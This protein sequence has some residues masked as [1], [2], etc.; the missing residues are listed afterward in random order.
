MR[1]PLEYTHS[2]YLHTPYLLTC[3]MFTFIY[4]VYIGTY[5]HCASHTS[6]T[7]ALCGTKRQ[8]WLCHS[9]NVELAQV[10]HLWVLVCGSN[11]RRQHIKSNRKELYAHYTDKRP[12]QVSVECYLMMIQVKHIYIYGSICS[13]DASVSVTVVKNAP[14]SH[15]T[16]SVQCA[17]NALNETIVFLYKQRRSNVGRKKKVEN[18]K[19]QQQQRRRN[20]RQQHNFLNNTRRSLNVQR[21]IFNMPIR[22]YGLL[23][24][25]APLNVS[26]RRRRVD[27]STDATGRC[28]CLLHSRLCIMWNNNQTA[29][30][31]NMFVVCGDRQYRFFLCTSPLFRSTIKIIC[32]FTF[33][34]TKQICM[35][36]HTDTI[37]C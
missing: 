1:L 13:C 4:N 12:S 35:Y 28:F 25:C 22:F 36:V 14:H 34:F 21:C 8:C 17:F 7:V 33:Y 27:R 16:Y 31:L 15:T 11:A 30:V 5:I 20:M 6:N 23:F 26:A 32:F 3:E 2:P 24:V 10:T 19:Q 29:R 9:C 18:P 37:Q